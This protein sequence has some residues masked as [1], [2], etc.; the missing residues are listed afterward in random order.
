MDAIF[1]KE[2]KIIQQKSKS[3]FI[4][5]GWVNW[6]FTCRRMKIVLYFSPCTKIKYKWIKDLN[7]KLDTL[8]LIE[9]KVG[10]NCEYICTK[11]N[12]LE[13][14]AMDQIL[15]SSIDKWDLIKLQSFW[16]AKNTINNT[17]CYPPDQERIFVNIIYLTEG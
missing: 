4:K 3:I 14:T 17:N 15:E 2:A 16:K 10:N 7:I 8:D 13:R 1:D 11:G 5:W 12:F 9:E 6:M